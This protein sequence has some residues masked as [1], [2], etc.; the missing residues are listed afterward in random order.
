ME[1]DVWTAVSF[2]NWCVAEGRQEVLR[3]DPRAR[4]AAVLGDIEARPMRC[5]LHRRCW[6]LPLRLIRA[7]WRRG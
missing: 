4:R 5:P 6:N 7:S 1:H 2:L 3:M